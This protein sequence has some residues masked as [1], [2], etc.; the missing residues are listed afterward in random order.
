M[1]LVQ[2]V[3]FEKIQNLLKFQ[4]NQ[5]VKISLNDDEFKETKVFKSIAHIIYQKGMLGLCN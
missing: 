4:H 2:K 3:D 1:I 5:M